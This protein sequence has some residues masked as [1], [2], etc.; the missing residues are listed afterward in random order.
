MPPKSFKDLAIC[1]SSVVLFL[2][3][4]CL[5]FRRPIVNPIGLHSYSASEDLNFI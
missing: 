5:K 1:V 4:E 3:R 2:G